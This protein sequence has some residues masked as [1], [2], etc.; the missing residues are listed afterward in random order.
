M[1][2]DSELLRRYAHERSEAAFAELVARHVD[3]V[4]SAALRQ[5]RGDHHRPRR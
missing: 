2:D 5:T 4:Y 3:L 1:T